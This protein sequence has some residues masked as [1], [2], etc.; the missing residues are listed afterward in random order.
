[1]I[2][3]YTVLK[4]DANSDFHVHYDVKEADCFKCL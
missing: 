4:S 1:M 2:I 3:A